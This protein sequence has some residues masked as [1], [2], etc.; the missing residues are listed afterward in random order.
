MVGAMTRRSPATLAAV[1][2]AVVALGTLALVVPAAGAPTAA[3]GVLLGAEPAAAVRLVANPPNEGLPRRW[4]AVVEWSF[5]DDTSSLEAFAKAT[6]VLASVHRTGGGS[7]TYNT[8]YYRPTGTLRAR[9]S[10]EAGGCSEKA[11]GTVAIK[12]EHGVLSINVVKQPGKKTYV[13]Y[14]SEN[15]GPYVVR[16]P[17]IPEKQ[18][19]RG[20][21]RSSVRHIDWLGIPGDSSTT[22]SAGKLE[23]T[24][25]YPLG[26]PPKSGF[27]KWCFTR[28]EADLESCKADELQAVASVSGSSLRAATR[29][30]DG[31]RSTGDIKSYTWTFS[32]APCSGPAVD[33]CAGACEATGPKPRARKRGERVTIK[34]LCS[35]LAT[36]TVSDGQ[37]EDSDSVEVMVSPRVQGWRTRV[38]HRWIPTPRSGAPSDAPIGPPR[39]SCSAPDQCTV[40]LRG[41]RNVPDPTSCPGEEFLGSRIFCPLLSGK[42]TW[43]ERGYT[44]AMVADPGGPFDGYAYVKRSTLTVTRLAYVNPDL[45][46]GTFYDYNKAQGAKV[47]DFIA[48][49]KNH[50]GWGAP[51]KPRTGHSQ[52]MRDVIAD[53][54]GRHDPRRELERL[55][56]P[57]AASLQDDADEK[58]KAID[59][60]VDSASDDPLEL[61]WEGNLYLYDPEHGLWTFGS[62]HVP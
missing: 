51:G 55:F 41:A 50:E 53:P 19:C 42:R 17:T 10:Y 37:N 25:D 35:I 21:T 61:I 4:Y 43:N 60:F 44:L 33:A 15:W 52:I 18:S 47:D 9:R 11:Q 20:H 14:T 31:S 56:A 59:E 8:Y 54:T 13:E 36:L 34:P 28:R 7:R 48:A 62:I 24:I 22:T 6:F 40:E 27:R 2:G 38:F 58:I 46:S 1:A 45:L 12:P 5:T 39:A 30:L 16:V 23:R 49:V 57:R 29:T 3:P 26:V 32:S